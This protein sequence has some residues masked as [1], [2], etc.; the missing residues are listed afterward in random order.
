MF[1]HHS[2][3]VLPVLIHALVISATVYG[4]EKGAALPVELFSFFWVYPLTQRNYEKERANSYLE[5]TWISPVVS[6]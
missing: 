6:K 1:L 2:T 3:C 4:N 5:M